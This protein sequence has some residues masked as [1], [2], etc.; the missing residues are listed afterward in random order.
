MKLHKSVFAAMAALSLSSAAA[1][2]GWLV[3]PNHLPQGVKPE[4][5]SPYTGPV[6]P[7]I[8]EGGGDDGKFELHRY[9]N[10]FFDTWR[11]FGTHFD[12]NILGEWGQG[13]LDNMKHCGAITT[14]TFAHSPDQSV[15]EW[16]AGWSLPLFTGDCSLETVRKIAQL[17]TDDDGNIIIRGHRQPEAGGHEA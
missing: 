14:W 11:L 17:H 2:S 12:K 13:L 6:G 10:A 4:P 7:P 1:A 9:T 3:D 16:A 5:G 15:W 8:R